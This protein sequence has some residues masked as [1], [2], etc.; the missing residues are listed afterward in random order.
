MAPPLMFK[1]VAEDAVLE[2]Q[3]LKPYLAESQ[4]WVGFCD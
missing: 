4:F 3:L 2:P 1:S